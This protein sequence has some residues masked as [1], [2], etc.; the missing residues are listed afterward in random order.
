MLLR[1]IGATGY[2]NAYEEK[3]YGSIVTAHFS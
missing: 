1:E 3:E 2:N